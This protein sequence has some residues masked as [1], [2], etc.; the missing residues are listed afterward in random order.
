MCAD[1]AGRR[2][3]LDAEVNA[4]RTPRELRLVRLKPEKD[5]EKLPE[6]ELPIPGEVIAEAFGLRLAARVTG[7]MGADLTP[8]KLRA[9]KA[10]DCVHLRYSAGLKRVK[11]VLER[12]KIPSDQ[13][14]NWPVLEWKGEIVWIR[15]SVAESNVGTAAG[16][17]IQAQDLT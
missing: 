16:L 17:E 9:H 11:E 2:E 1:K 15:G 6:Y 12:L 8:A 7:D 4:E 14:K 13:R 10:G 5:A 3:T